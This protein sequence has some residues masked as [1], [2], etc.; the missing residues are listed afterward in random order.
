[1]PAKG[2]GLAPQ[3]PIR[4][5]RLSIRPW[6]NDESERYHEVRG[7]AEVTRYLY[8]PPLTRRQAATKL[9][10]LR[11]E[12]RRPGEWINLAVEVNATRTVVGD[13]G[14]GWTSQVHRQAEV[15]YS[16]H[17]EHGGRG[18]ATEA[19]AAM[20]GLAFS[21]LDVHRVCGRLDARN[22]ASARLL[23]RLGMRYEGHLV[24]NELVK[25]EWTDEMIYAVLASEWSG[26]RPAHP[27]P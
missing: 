8:D 3:Y 19:A 22:S 26:S 6:R 10:G 20:V 2:R 12:I 4:T 15:G 24:E 21:G 5:D 25:G 14:L 1:V 7:T 13:V 9:R 23:E 17:P 11:T 18:Y 16:F 27:D